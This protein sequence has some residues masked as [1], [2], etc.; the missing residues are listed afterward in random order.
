MKL[1]ILSAL[2]FIGLLIA[3]AAQAQSGSATYSYSGPPFT[4][5]Y[6][7]DSC[8]LICGV[9]GSFTMAQPLAPNLAF[10]PVTP[11]SFSFTDGSNVITNLNYGQGNSII[12]V[13]TDA[14]G[15]ILYWQIELTESNPPD[16]VTEHYL[17]TSPYFGTELIT[18]DESIQDYYSDEA[19]EE[20][21]P[22]TWT[23]TLANHSFLIES[24]NTEPSAGVATSSDPD[25]TVQCS[26]AA[27]CP[28]KLQF[29]FDTINGQQAVLGSP[30]VLWGTN[31]LYAT[32]TSINLGTLC[33]SNNTMSITN[34]DSSVYYFS[35]TDGSNP[36]V[37]TSSSPSTG[38][39]CLT[40][41][42]MED[43]FFNFES[44]PFSMYA[45]PAPGGYY[46][47]TFNDAASG[48]H[49][50]AGGSGNDI[51]SLTINSD[52][53][54]TST[55]V[56]VPYDLCPQQSSLLNLTSTDPLA[57]A[58]AAYPYSVG[59]IQVGDVTLAVLGDG[60]GNVL[61]I[62]AGDQD[63]NGNVLPAGNLYVT[64]YGVSG[65]CAGTYFYD[66]PFATKG[67]KATPIRRT[68]PH[69]RL[70]DRFEREFDEKNPNR[71]QVAPRLTIPILKW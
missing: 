50:S 20:S 15:N 46:V 65:V 51:M 35:F 59:G 52:F 36:C 41:P 21:G 13:S 70:N 5:F 56:A 33:G 29:V 24:T 38:T 58:Y 57:L 23:T 9:T 31:S 39:Y 67:V 49:T 40:I 18:A 43:C 64:G 16:I 6:G 47:G 44:G 62:I 27:P 60:T 10:G 26:V 48:H 53:S 19:F 28:Q 55:L 42:G 2:I 14:S 37:S 45:Y 25:A 30:N 61:A 3:P 66:R 1:K 54:V 17:Y 4:S 71:E 32:G 34:G 63:A 11:E 69:H 7:T 68:P 22:G 8:P 12:S